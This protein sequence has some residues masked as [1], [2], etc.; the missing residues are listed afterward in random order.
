[1]AKAKKAAKKG[2]AEDVGV[3]VVA[4]KVRA[5]VRGKGVNMSSEVIEALD[6]KV[7]CLLVKAIERTV[8]N[9][10]KTLRAV[11]L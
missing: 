6:G 10:R 5:V 2:K 11:D 7:K 1:V 3:V 4:S 9:K 8:G